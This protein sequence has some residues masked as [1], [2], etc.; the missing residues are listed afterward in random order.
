MRHSE[1][2]RVRPGAVLKQRLERSDRVKGITP[3]TK[4]GLP[5]QTGEPPYPRTPASVIPVLQLT[6]ER[7]GY[8]SEEDL[9]RVACYTGAAA[10]AVY[11]V[12]TFYSQFRLQ[13]SGEHTIRVCEG[14][15]CHVLGA[16]TIVEMLKEKLAV[17]VGQTTQDGL[18]TLESVR[19]LGC[20]SLAPAMMVDDE[21]F[22]RL[23]P[24]VLDGI[25]AEYREEGA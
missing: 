11:G 9:E 19:C 3:G 1:R 17:D 15:A 22:G 5:D 14:T 16:G 7:R 10:S 21:T 6:Q 4:R 20:C 13:A 23:T 18:F 24:D 8:I 2:T 25:L 12:A